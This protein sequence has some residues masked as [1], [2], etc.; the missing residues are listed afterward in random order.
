MAVC[1]ILEPGRNGAVVC[2]ECVT[3]ISTYWAEPGR[4]AAGTLEIE[5]LFAAGKLR[6]TGGQY[7]GFT[8]W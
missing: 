4:N 3:S 1:A 7:A 8:S 5:G 2:F 6:I